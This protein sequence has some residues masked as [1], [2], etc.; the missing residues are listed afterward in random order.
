MLKPA[1]KQSGAQAKAAGP[2]ASTTSSSVNSTL[3]FDTRIDSPFSQVNTLWGAGY[4]LHSTFSPKDESLVFGIYCIG[5]GVTGTLV[6]TASFTFTA[7][8]GVASG[9]IQI[10]G[11]LAAT[12]NIATASVD[13]GD[14]WGFYEEIGLFA[15]AQLLI[16]GIVTVSPTV[17]L[18]LVGSVA[19]TTLGEALA[20]ATF[21]WPSVAAT[22]DIVNPSLSIVAGF[23]SPQ[24]QPSFNLQE[25]I[26]IGGLANLIFNLTYQ[27][28]LFDGLF[29]NTVALVQMPA[30]DFNI[31]QEQQLLSP[32]GTVTSSTA[33]PLA[34]A[35]VSAGAVATS[36]PEASCPDE[37]LSLFSAGSVGVSWLNLTYYTLDTWT[38]P[39]WSTC[40]TGA[41]GRKEKA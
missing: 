6:T 25:D 18:E 9:S 12:L 19:A 16:P 30:L 2:V 32:D 40:I 22:L 11:D 24:I 20:G 21:T 36:A 37:T 5:C 29:A 23:D 26:I 13:G 34:T 41:V 1:G 31:T 27:V 38:G 33:S 10:N 14:S 3:S 7:A 8:G 4:D 35:S 28:M 39:Y 17:S 15:A